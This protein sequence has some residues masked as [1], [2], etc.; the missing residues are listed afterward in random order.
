[1]YIDMQCHK[2]TSSH[3]FSY[4]CVC[5]AWFDSVT[6]W[7]YNVWLPEFFVSLRMQSSPASPAPNK[8]LAGRC[9]ATSTLKLVSDIYC[10]AP[11]QIIS[12]IS[13]GRASVRSWQA[14]R[15][16]LELAITLRRHRLPG[17]D[18]L[19][20]AFFYRWQELASVTFIW[21]TSLWFGC[22]AK[23][24][25]DQY[26]RPD[27]G[28]E[29]PG[30]EE[31]L[32]VAKG[33]VGQDHVFLNEIDAFESTST[34]DDSSDTRC[35]FFVFSLCLILCLCNPTILRVDLQMEAVF[36][37]TEP[38][39]SLS[40]VPRWRKLPPRLNRWNIF[41]VDGRLALM[42]PVLA[43]SIVDTPTEQL[44][45][46]CGSSHGKSCESFSC[47][48]AGKHRCQAKIYFTVSWFAWRVALACRPKAGFYGFQFFMKIAS[49]ERTT[50]SPIW[51]VRR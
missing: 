23:E 34:S 12:R 15:D 44:I 48:T 14:W 4:S 28:L 49:A 9:L 20:L 26:T 50:S 11:V 2:D 16:C 45:Y 31:R 13:F 40:F 10:M 25:I 17:Q 29:T 43:A 51:S 1:M 7:A 42:K 24:K 5:K 38:G 3:C 41:L 36:V 39:A 21:L 33:E 32:Q 6:L 8:S 46:P 18:F 47:C 35:F 30:L 22:E 27:E 19:I 37:Q